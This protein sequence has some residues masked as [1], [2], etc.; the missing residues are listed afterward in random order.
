VFCVTF[1]FCVL[2]SIWSNSQAARLLL[3]TVFN[4][5][6]MFSECLELRKCYL[7]CLEVCNIQMV[8][9]YLQCCC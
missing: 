8:A 3:P 5:L 1:T 9:K 6:L 4:C 2:L 7:D